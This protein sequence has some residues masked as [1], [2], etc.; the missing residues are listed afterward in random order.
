MTPAPFVEGGYKGMGEGGAIGAPAAITNAVADALAPFGVRI[1]QTPLTPARILALLDG[2][3]D[4]RYTPIGCTARRPAPGGA[5]RSSLTADP[6]GRRPR[7]GSHDGERGPPASRRAQ[8]LPE[9]PRAAGGHRRHH[10]R[11]GDA[12]NF[13]PSSARRVAASRRC[14]R[15]SPGWCR[16]PAGRC[17]STAAVT[18]PAARAPSTSSSSTPSRSIPGRPCWTT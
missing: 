13:T 12:R 8:G 4:G 11:R 16:P 18:V 2:A 10:G 17:C 14:C 1:A 15:S 6:G 9:R 5:V 3:V 7:D